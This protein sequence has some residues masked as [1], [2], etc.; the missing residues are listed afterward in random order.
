MIWRS[1]LLQDK[2][3]ALARMFMQGVHFFT[4]PTT[5]FFSPQWY[6]KPD[7]NF[8][9]TYKSYRKLYPN[10]PFYMLRPQM[11]WELWDIMQEISPDWIQPNPPSSGMLGESGPGEVLRCFLEEVD[12]LLG[13]H[14]FT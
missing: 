3:V 4:D 1:D 5:S 6:K 10:Q 13:S 11:P 7:Y 14:S 2:A 12:F 9:E 8:F